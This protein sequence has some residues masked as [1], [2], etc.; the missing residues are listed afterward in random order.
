VLGFSGAGLSVASLATGWVFWAIRSDEWKERL[1]EDPD[2]DYD[3]YR[4]PVL[5]FTAMGSAGLSA[6]LPAI[7]PPQRGVPWWSYLAGA[8]G[9]GLAVYGIYVWQQDEESCQESDESGCTRQ[10]RVDTLGGPFFA[11]QGLPLLA[12]PVTYLVR[13][14]IGNEEAAVAARLRLDRGRGSL[15]LTGRF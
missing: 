4:I 11:M 15:A 14:L 5:A 7:L 6:S 12:V 10:T 3:G 8:G 1:A 13:H 9:V 2:D